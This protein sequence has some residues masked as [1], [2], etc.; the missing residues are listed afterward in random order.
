[1]PFTL[2]R[3][4]FHLLGR[5]R[6]GRPYGF[7]PDGDSIQFKPDDLALIDRL[8]QV[9]A[10][11]RPNSF[12]SLQLRFEGIDALELHFAPGNRHGEVSQPRPLADEARDLLIALLGMEPVA[13]VPPRGLT[14]DEAPSDGA[15]GY[16]LSR[17][18]EVHGRPVAFVFAGEPP[19]GEPDGAEVFLDGGWLRESLNYRLVRAGQAYP[20]FY[21]T[22]FYDLRA[23]YARAALEARAAGS[24]LW[25]RDRST[26]GLVAEAMAPLETEGVIFPKLFRRL[27]EYF[28]LHG[29]GVAGFRDWL[30]AEKPEQVIVL[31]LMHV[32]H[33]DDVLTVDLDGVRLDYR[34]E[35]LVFISAK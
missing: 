22:L 11:P 31:P 10:A 16:I 7:E 2:I 19:G 27:A 5:D 6:N 34:P 33:L 1:M 21:D 20:L 13:Y 30:E 12:G 23:E 15:R 18:L 29:D 24:G 35:E 32:T 28:A 17:A 3:G 9:G 26:L 4:A 14:V 8:T 25:A